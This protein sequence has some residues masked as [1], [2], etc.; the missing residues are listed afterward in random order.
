MLKSFSAEVEG[1]Q[2]DFNTMNIQRPQLFQ[3][4]AEHE[5]QRVRFHMQINDEGVFRI[6][7]KDACPEPF[8]PLEPLLSATILQHAQEA[9]QSQ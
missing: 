6:A 1:V 3:V 2:F 9:E 5:G 8:Q 4:Y 7:L